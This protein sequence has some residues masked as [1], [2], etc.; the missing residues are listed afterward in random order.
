MAQSARPTRRP[1]PKALQT[2]SRTPTVVAVAVVLVLGVAVIGGVLFSGGGSSSAID[3]SP[4]AASYPTVVQGDTIVAGTGPTKID[5]YE[6]LLCPACQQFETVYGPKIGDALG[7]G[8]VQVTY[9]LVNLL[10]QSS[11]PPGYSTLAGNAMMCAAENGAFAGLHQALYAQQPREGGK[12]YTAD[13]LVT[14]G[15]QAG[16]GPGYEAC[17]RSGTHS[18]AMS[19]NLAAAE[20]DPALQQTVSGRT[21][22]GTPTIQV[23]GRTVQ[24]GGPELAAALS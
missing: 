13:Q 2:K 22:F 12:A 5:V 15:Q 11:N 14:A 4:A 16:A 17:V 6:D 8:K 9:H 18:P 1:A 21:G 7:A 3:A 23:D 10:E 20:N 24:P 19:A